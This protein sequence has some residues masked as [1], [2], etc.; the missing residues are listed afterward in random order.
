MNNNNSITNNHNSNDEDDSNQIVLK[1]T[2]K[3]W[4]LEGMVKFIGKPCIPDD[5]FFS[6]P[7]CSG[8]YPN[9]D[10]KIYNQDTK[11]LVLKTKTESKG[12]FKAILEPGEYVIYTR[13][14]FYPSDLKPTYFTIEKGKITK[15]HTLIVD[16]GTE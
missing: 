4:N 16:E 9:Y 10:I 8:P 15:L 13:N 14:G 11:K 7:P 12:N 1:S 2:D 3:Y 5:K 6:V